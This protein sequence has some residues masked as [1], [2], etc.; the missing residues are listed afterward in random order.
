MEKERFVFESV[1]IVNSG[2][3]TVI[4]KY[5]VLFQEPFILCASNE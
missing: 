1:I 2:S 4:E 5:E 3:V